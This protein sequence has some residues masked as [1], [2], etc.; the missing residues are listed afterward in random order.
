VTDQVFPGFLEGQYHAAD[1]LVRQSDILELTPLG[2]A[3][4]ITRYIAEFHCASLGF[5]RVSREV[6]PVEHTQV[7][8][9]FPPNYLQEFETAAVVSWLGP[10][11]IWHPN[12]RPPY[13]CL[14]HMAPGTIIEDILFQIYEIISFQRVGMADPLNSAACAW[15]RQNQARFPL[16][17]RP[18]KRRSVDLNIE[19]MATE[20]MVEETHP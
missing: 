17:N 11:S 16:D 13:M 12:I 1:H 5:N 6:E 2:E 18:L 15:A 8:I 10:I 4:F 14:G 20:W 7:G 19:K 3:P 9:W